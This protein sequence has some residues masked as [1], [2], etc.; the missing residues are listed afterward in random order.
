[1]E[2]QSIIFNELQGFNPYPNLAKPKMFEV[3]LAHFKAFFVTT[4]ALF[5]PSLFS[6]SCLKRLVVEMWLDLQ[7][8]SFLPTTHTRTL[9]AKTATGSLQ[10][11]PT[12]S[13]PWLLSGTSGH[14]VH[15]T[16]FSCFQFSRNT[17]CYIKH[18]KWNCADIVNGLISHSYTVWSHHL[19]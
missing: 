14:N 19:I 12:M 18:I 15:L 13:F 4:V 5:H 3:V 9:T 7:D 1:M 6:L 16:Y 8:L 17:Q 2:L 11:T 10:S